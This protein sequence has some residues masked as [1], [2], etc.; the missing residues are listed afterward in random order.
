MAV[1][2]T[3]WRGRAILHI[4]MDAFFASV[5][6]L[7]DPRL[8]GR[9]VIV[10]GDPSSRGVVA[11]ASYEARAFGVR[12]AMA[13]ATAA[14]LCPDAVWVRPRF[15]RY[16]EVAEDV[17][18]VLR[19]VTPLVEV[20]SIDEAYLDVTPGET[21]DD[22]VAH[23]R[24]IADAVR[25]MG[26]SCSIGV[27][28]SKTVAK[29]ASDQR[30][31]GGLVVVR[32][33]EEAAFL[34]PLPVGAM[35][36]I[37]PAAQKRLGRLGIFTLGGLAALDE[38]SAAAALGSFGQVAVLRARG[39]DP[40]AVVTERPVKSISNEATFPADLPFAEAAQRLEPLVAKV[41]SRLRARGL[42]GRTLT[43]KVRYPDMATRSA[44]MTLEQPTDLEQEMLPAARELL[45]SLSRPGA[46]VRLLGFGVSG[47]SE[48]VQQMALIDAERSS[49]DRDR[50]SA[51]ARN[52]DEIRK[53]FGP[54]AVRRGLKGGTGG[55]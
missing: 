12:S 40:R 51:L 5:E 46:R 53:R 6:Q 41:A 34:A 2:R 44:Q 19:S 7:D 14:R 32:P 17:R 21:G 15:E 20:A 50:A 54:G 45:A 18:R 28:T 55:S 35:S 8:R 27:A 25:G 11:T 43:V 29:I 23:A 26:L 24:A 33:G 22:P 42:A 9:P 47:L 37:G 1:E 30:K 52:L 38:A 48:P 10:G 49:S 4:D 31:P 36:G 39:I 16:R 13:S 3:A